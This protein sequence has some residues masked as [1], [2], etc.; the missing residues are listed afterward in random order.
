MVIAKRPFLIFT[1]VNPTRP[2]YER[3]RQLHRANVAQNIPKFYNYIE[4]EVVLPAHQQKSPQLRGV[5]V[6]RN[7]NMIY[8]KYAK[9]CQYICKWDDDILLPPGIINACRQVFEDDKDIVGVGLFQE[10]YGAPQI[11]M[12]DTVKDGW[13]GAFSRFYCYRVNSWGLIPIDEK[14]GDPDNAFQKNIVGKKFVLDVPN[15]HLDHRYCTE[16]QYKVFLDITNFFAF[17]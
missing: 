3:L 11:L 9:D 15:V 14:R 16:K 10:E 6:C 1:P 17:S 7:F 8:R 12:T 4:K 2:F 13:Y 5:N